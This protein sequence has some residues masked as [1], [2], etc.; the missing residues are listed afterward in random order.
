MAAA[1][2][3]V[4][5]A[6]TDTSNFAWMGTGF[7]DREARDALLRAWHAHADRTGADPDYITDEWINVV[8]GPV[9]TGWQDYEPVA[10]AMS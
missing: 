10:P 1:P 2:V 9:G 3:V 7:T 5:I 4:Y 6:T 8:H